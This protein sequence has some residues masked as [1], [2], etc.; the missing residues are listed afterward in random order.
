MLSGVVCLKSPPIRCE[1]EEIFKSDFF[2][3]GAKEWTS[4][5]R[6]ERTNL[7]GLNCITVPVRYSDVIV[8]MFSIIDAVNI[9]VEL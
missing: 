1:E 9:A 3:Y 6:C 7:E 8:F 4:S 5:S 2:A